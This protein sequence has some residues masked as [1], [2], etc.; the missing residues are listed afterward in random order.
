ML[1]STSVR[2]SA[3]GR[4]SAWPSLASR[5]TSGGAAFG[6]ARTK[7]TSTL[8][9][10]GAAGPTPC[11]I[12]GCDGAARAPPAAAGISSRTLVSLPSPDD[13]PKTVTHA[14]ING[15]KVEITHPE[16]ESIAPPPTACMGAWVWWW[17]RRR[18]CSGDVVLVVLAL[19]VSIISVL[20]LALLLVPAARTAVP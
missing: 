14:T 12:S 18:W 8:R 6:Q 15:R 3:R 13:V 16:G 1:L 17:R 4:M 5:L 20:M 10:A 9:C 11:S 19:V 2:V 7:K